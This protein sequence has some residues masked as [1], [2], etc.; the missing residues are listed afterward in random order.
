MGGFGRAG[1]MSR[2]ISLLLVAGVFGTLGFLSCRVID[3]FSAREV[4]TSRLSPNETSRVRLV[5]FRTHLIDRNFSIQLEQLET[6]ATVDLL[7]WSPDEGEPR[8]T[9]RFLWSKD[10][11][12]VLLVG[13]HFFVRD[14]MFLDN[15][16]QAY[17]LHDFKANRSWI[18][19]SQDERLPA[20]TAD[21]I[22]GVEFT[23]PVVLKPRAKVDPD[24]P[25]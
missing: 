2:R 13:R 22:A 11:T 20:L 21:L 1:A 6:G 25:K 7:P 3:W 8:G 14:D 5:D 12:K 9:E 23:E 16:D 19:S 24:S 15:G 17:F 4:T 10:G 18:N